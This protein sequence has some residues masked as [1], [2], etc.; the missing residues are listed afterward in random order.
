[1]N[2]VTSGPASGQPR[3][4]N[5]S[6][7]V[8]PLVVVALLAAAPAVVY[9][10]F[11]MKLMC[12]VLFAASFDLLLG[13]AGL[14]SFGHAAFLGTGAYLTAYAAQAWGLDPLLC[15]LVGMVAAALVGTVMGFLAIRRKGIEFAMITLALAQ[16]VEFIAQQASFTGGEDGIHDVPRGYVFGLIDLNN[17]TAIYITMLVLFV[18]GMFVLWRTI[19]SPF[20]HVLK[21]IRDH[22][23]RAISLGYDVN[24][25]KLIAFVIASVI[26]GLAGG[27]KAIVFQLATLDD[28][29]FHVSGAVILMVLLG[30]VGTLYGPL[31]GATIVV[32]LESALATSEFPAP[33]ITGAVFIL[34]VLMFRRGVVGEIVNWL[35]ERQTRTSRP[36][37]GEA[38]PPTHTSDAHS[39]DS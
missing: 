28:A 18:V 22:E 24:R 35:A 10:V 4:R 13:Y 12:Y 23:D 34:C 2:D 25:Y 36:R 11:V 9:P 39:I 19:N 37:R 17:V 16:V 7:I 27:M 29:S 20:G 31:I 14:L 32:A 21:A 15:L 1:M 6:T 8:G 26:A 38:A 3:R 5:Q 33:V 30:G